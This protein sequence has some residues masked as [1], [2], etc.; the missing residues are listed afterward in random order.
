VLRQRGADRL[1]EEAV[2][3]ANR[4]GDSDHPEATEF[5]AR[6][7]S[8]AEGRPVNE[9]EAIIERGL[10]QLPH[11]GRRI[12][13]SGLDPQSVVD[14]LLNRRLEATWNVRQTREP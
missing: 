8:A 3:L 14:L 4:Y 12:D 7:Q 9:F 6:L 13:P 10:D 11:V 2:Y 5:A 1:P